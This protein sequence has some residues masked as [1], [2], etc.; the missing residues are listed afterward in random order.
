[1]IK[2]QFEIAVEFIPSYSPDVATM[3]ERMVRMKESGV[4][5]VSIVSN[6]MGKPKLPALYAAQLMDGMFN[7]IVHYPC[8]GRSSIIFRSDMMEAVAIGVEAVLIL[9]G[10]PH[11]ECSAQ[12]IAADRIKI[13]KTEPFSSMLVGAAASAQHFSI[14]N[15]KEKKDAGADFF[16]TQPVFDYETMINFMDKT[17][18]LE[19]PTFVGIMVPRSIKQLESLKNI[20]GVVIPGSYF[21]LFKDVTGEGE[22]KVTAVKIALD[23]IAK[24]KEICGGVYLSASPDMI[25]CFE[26]VFGG[27]RKP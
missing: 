5:T 10:D 16:E 4:E 21:D 1:M 2:G 19:V 25:P 6:P 20:P 15:L 9:A 27:A 17:S 14:D 3:V 24:A 8:S 12:V 13:L 18:V 22:F 7:R 11:P 23:L 26:D